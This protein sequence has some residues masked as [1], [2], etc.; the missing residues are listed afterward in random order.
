MTILETTSGVI[1]YSKTSYIVLIVLG[2]LFL[3]SILKMIISNTKEKEIK[4]PFPSLALLSFIFFCICIFSPA[5][6][7]KVYFNYASNGDLIITE[8]NKTDVLEL[9]TNNLKIYHNR[10]ELVFVND[11]MIKT[12]TFFNSVTSKNIC[13]ELKGLIGLDKEGDYGLSN[14]N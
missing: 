9:E 2:L 13:N 12:Y 7:N 8:K 5:N 10:K 6:G 14:D 11:E 1:S 3:F 4:E